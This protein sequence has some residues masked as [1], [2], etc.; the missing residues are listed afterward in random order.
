MS[1]IATEGYGASATNII[2]DS[3]RLYASVDETIF[4]YPARDSQPGNKNAL[5]LTN[6]QLKKL[7]FFLTTTSRSPET[8]PFNQPKVGIWPVPEVNSS[9]RPVATFRSA[10]DNLIAFCSTLNSYPYYFTRNNSQSATADWTT[11]ND[12]IFD[13][14]DGLFQNP[15]PGFGASLDSRYTVS[16]GRRILTLIYDY[17]RSTFNL[18]DTSFGSTGTAPN[19]FF[20]NTF[21]GTANN[22]Q[23]EGYGQVVPIQITK[24]GTNFKGVGRF[25]LIKQVA[26][27]F[28]VRAANQPPVQCY[29]NGRP[30]VYRKIASS[31]YQVINGTDDGHGTLVA[32]FKLDALGNVIPDSI[33][34]IIPAYYPDVF[35]GNAYAS[36]NPQHPWVAGS[37]TD[38]NLGKTFVP[39]FKTTIG[40][41]P[42]PVLAIDTTDPRFTAAPYNT[43]NPDPAAFFPVFGTGV[44]DRISGSSVASITD[45]TVPSASGYTQYPTLYG[46]ATTNGY[47]GITAG[48]TGTITGTV[49]ARKVWEGCNRP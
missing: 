17:I 23:A 25:P 38:A 7:R 1:T 19:L 37:V 20:N 33:G 12:Q 3:D 4:G 35:L 14:L 30:I 21:M 36:L 9:T 46:T 2:P 24:S 28:M 29:F 40:G 49:T 16:G 10:A 22:P 44:T 31:T 6:D 48:T 11:R 26:V 41:V 32:N 5:S 18:L 27:M 47:W 8:N 34:S 13:Y 15:V 42:V 45:N 43:T 39:Q